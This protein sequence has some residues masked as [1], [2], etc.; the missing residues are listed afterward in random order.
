MIHQPLYSHHLASA[1]YD[2]A[3]RMLEI[4]FRNGA[5]YRYYEVPQDVFDNLMKAVSPGSYFAA[6][7]KHVYV[8][9]NIGGVRNQ[10]ATKE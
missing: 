3:R 9:I 8:A 7:I 6:A 2:V 5:C 4:K 10:M 1:A